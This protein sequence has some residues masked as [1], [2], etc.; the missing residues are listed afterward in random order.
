[1][2]PGLVFEYFSVISEKFPKSM[3]VQYLKAV[4]DNS[5]DLNPAISDEIRRLDKCSILFEL[6][7]YEDCITEALDVLILYSKNPPIIQKLTKL[8]F[9]SQVQLGKYNEAIQIYVEQYLEN[10]ISVNKI[11][12][13]DLLE[14]MRSVKYK[15]I[16]RTNGLVIFTT[17][18]SNDDAEKAFIL[19]TV[20]SIFG[21]TMPSELFDFF[22]D[23]RE[24]ELFLFKCCTSEI[25]KHYIYLNKTLARLEER[26]KILNY[27]LQ[28]FSDPKK[29]YSKQLDHITNEIIIYEG[30]RKLDESKIYANDQAIIDNELQEIEG[31]FSRFKTIY[32]IISKD[33]NVILLSANSYQFIKISPKSDRKDNDTKYTTSALLE[34][35]SEIFDLIL[36]KYLFSKF[37]IVAYLSTRIRHGVLGGEIRPEIDKHN[38]ILNRKSNSLEY[39]DSL[40]WAKPYYGL[41]ISELKKLNE[42]LSKFSLNVDNIIEEILKHK[43][44]IKVDNHNTEGLF[45]YQFSKQE[46]NAMAYSLAKEENAKIF[47]Q[48]IIDNIWERTDFNLEVI[49]NYFNED[50]SIKFH[51]AFTQ[52]EDDLRSHFGEK[53]KDIYTK[54]VGCNT[55]IANRLKKI[56]EWFKRTGSTLD[57]FDIN[58]LFQIIWQNTEKCY[59][60]G[61]AQLEVSAKSQFPLIQS[62]YYIHFTDLFRIFIDNMFKYSSIENGEKSFKIELDRSG[63]IFVAVFQNN[64][65]YENCDFFTNDS[66]VNLDDSKLTI[67]KNSGISKSVK[68]IKYDLNDISNNLNISYRAL[69]ESS[70]LYLLKLTLSI[71]LKTLIVNEKDFN[72]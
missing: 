25:L 70:D 47:S 53:I 37:G 7:R 33:Q 59:P 31:L 65:S 49:R 11:N 71:N 8:I 1:M 36:Q 15:G 62:K 52:L 42:I 44:Q 72:C 26:Q 17:L 30:T 50:V 28:N 43:I 18:T 2:T 67:E 19:E 66:E 21:I 27:L 5:L 35:F 56:G 23:N 4:S 51:Y 40:Y 55:I 20:I 48:K 41:N 68:I 14:K 22:P 60:N 69:D 24:K 13:E 34:V 45:N 38:L 63:E 57:N 64:T 54:I 39:H 3:A 12:P 10:P 58:N 32:N 16:K 61:K 29:L 46:L 9:E 6:S